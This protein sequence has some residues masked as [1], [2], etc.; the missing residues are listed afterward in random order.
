MAV[1]SEINEEFTMCL[2]ILACSPS[3]PRVSGT[4]DE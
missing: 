2:L 4:V 1:R 3:L